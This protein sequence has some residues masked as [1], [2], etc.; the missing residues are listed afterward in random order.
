MNPTHTHPTNKT[1]SVFQMTLT[2]ILTVL[3]LATLLF[4]AYHASQKIDRYFEIVARHDCA[5]DY[6]LQYT[7]TVKKTVIVRP[8]DDLYEQCLSQKGIQ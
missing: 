4:I 7:D 2:A 8:L 5:Q 3:S 1:G 6:H